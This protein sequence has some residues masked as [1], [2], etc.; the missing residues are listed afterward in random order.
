MI[1]EDLSEFTSL[2]TMKKQF[3]NNWRIL[4]KN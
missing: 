1:F 2:K 4:C 3:G